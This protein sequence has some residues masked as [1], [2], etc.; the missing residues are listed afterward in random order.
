M[1]ERVVQKLA[2]SYP[3]RRAAK[4][5]AYILTKNNMIGPGS[6]SNPKAIAE[7]IKKLKDSFNK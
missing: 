6:S 2:D 7:A 5:I 4:Y 3:I 1:N